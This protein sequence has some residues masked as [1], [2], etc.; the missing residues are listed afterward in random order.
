MVPALAQQEI[1]SLKSSLVAN[2][3]VRQQMECSAQEQRSLLESI[4]DE[5]SVSRREK[6]SLDIENKDMRNK[7][8]VLTTKHNQK[9]EVT[10]M[11]SNCI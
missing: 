5:L 7:L 1:D 10:K 2:E 4:Q 8:A 9:D 3:S 6:D 11:Y